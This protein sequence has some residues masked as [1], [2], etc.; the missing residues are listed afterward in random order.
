MTIL[1]T[2]I[3]VIL[4]FTGS[5]TIAQVELVVTVTNISSSRGNILVALYNSE[6]TF[7]KKKYHLTK[8]VATKGAV[9]VKLTDVPAGEYAIAVLHDENCDEKFNSNFYGKPVEG[10]GFSN[11]VRGFFGPPS[12]EKVRIKLAKSPAKIAIRLR[13]L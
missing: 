9:E 10:F 11:N 6:N 13:Y 1:K 5:K 8:A 7:L 2:C 4:L 3:I 12:Y